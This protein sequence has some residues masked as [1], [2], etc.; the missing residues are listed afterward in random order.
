MKNRSLKS[1]LLFFITFIVILMTTINLYSVFHTK[2]FQGKYSNLIGRLATINNINQ[3]IKLSVLYFEKYFTTNAPSDW[4]ES[5]SYT[6][7]AMSK[8]ES[9][10]GVLDEES[11]ITLLDMKGVIESYK[12]SAI[13]AMTAFIV[14]NK[15]NDFYPHFQETK[16][17]SGYCDEY[18]K[19]LQD[20]YLKYNDE[21]YKILEKDTERNSNIMISLTILIILWCMIF[22][23]IFSD[24]I[25]VPLEKLVLYSKNVSKGK[26]ETVKVTSSKIYE[27]DI[28]AEGFNEMVNAIDT[29]IAKIKEK[30]HVEKQLKDQEMKNLLVENLLKETQLKVLQSQI[31][32]HFL[33]NTLNAIIQTAEIEDAH[34]TEKLINSVSDI[35]RYSLI[36]LDSQSCVGDEVEIIKKYAHIQETRFNDR[37]KFKVEVENKLLKVPLPGMTLQPLVENAFIHGV[38]E[39]EEGGTI[40]VKIYEENEKCVIVIQDDGVGMTQKKI[41]EM[42][43]AEASSKEKHH[44]SGIGLANVIKRLRV[45][46]NTSDV[47]TIE[48]SIGQ[49][50]KMIIRI[51]I[52]KEA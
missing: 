17:I 27:I 8:V 48:S 33:F 6:D 44:T 41:M 18:I 5:R 9:L 49:G 20:N 31:N 50:T 34:E 28:L 23:V 25:T 37:I 30:A 51:P 10:Q 16:K 45:L 24:T 13:D 3:D 22:A 26:F 32:P 4:K 12:D 19:K 15:A 47:F 29:L 35:L 36:M 52:S 21:Q 42:L 1:N 38:E 2:S 43:S 14:D 40:A 46:Y 11:E 7:S 39:K